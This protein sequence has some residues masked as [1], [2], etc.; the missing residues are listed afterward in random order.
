MFYSKVYSKSNAYT[1]VP[2]VETSTLPNPAD[3]K[4]SSDDDLTL[5]EADDL[6]FE[7]L[8]VKTFK[9]LDL[10]KLTQAHFVPREPIIVD[11]EV[12]TRKSTTLGNVVLDIPVELPLN[13][14]KAQKEL[15]DVNKTAFENLAKADSTI[16]QLDQRISLAII[17]LQN[18][19]LREKFYRELSDDPVKFIENWLESQAETLKALKSDEGYDEEVVRRAKY[20]EENEHLI[21]EKLNF[22]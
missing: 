7:L 3:D 4:D 19:N 11:Y 5:V 10:Y 1:E 20:F 13:L 16:L 12:D 2:A 22:C 9:F 21:K 15:L 6:L 14:L 18:A 8:K 17:A